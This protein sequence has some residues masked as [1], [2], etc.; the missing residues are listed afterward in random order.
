MLLIKSAQTILELSNIQSIMSWR[1]ATS[2]FESCA[3]SGAGC[4]PTLATIPVFWGLYRTLS[5]VSQAGLLTEGFY[6]IPSL[7]G[8][9]SL[10]DQRAGRVSPSLNTLSQQCTRPDILKCQAHATH[11]SSATCTM[12]PPLLA[13]GEGPCRLQVK[14]AEL[15]PGSAQVL[16]QPGCCPWPMER[17]R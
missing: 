8:P 4:L 16:G 14:S 2:A 3:V 6:W 11:A 10:A 13:S 9:A 17:R 15:C 5:N 7:S 12:A 1:P